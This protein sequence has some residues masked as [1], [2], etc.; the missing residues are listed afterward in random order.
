M[1]HHFSI[2]RILI[3]A[4]IAVVLFSARGWWPGNRPPGG[5]SG[6]P[7]NPGGPSPA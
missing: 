4:I 1:S 3:L 7:G 5:W 2:G 6:G